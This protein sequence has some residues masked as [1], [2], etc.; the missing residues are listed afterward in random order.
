MSRDPLA[1]AT[2]F[3]I[4]ERQTRE[5]QRRAIAAVNLQRQRLR[6]AKRFRLGERCA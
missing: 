5:V 4:A 6:A 1:S 2:I 3:W